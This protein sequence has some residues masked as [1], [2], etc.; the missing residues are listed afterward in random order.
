MNLGMM[1]QKRILS[2]ACLLALFS[3]PT[4]A[5][6]FDE[7]AVINQRIG[8]GRPI[9]APSSTEPFSKASAG[10]NVDL[11]CSAM[12]LNSEMLGSF[13]SGAFK[14]LQSSLV[15]QLMA[16]VNP[17]SLI[18][19]AIQRA[20][21]DVYDM[22][23][24]GSMTATDAFNANVMTCQ[25]MQQGVFDSLPAGALKN[26]TVSEEY[27]EAIKKHANGN[28]QL[29]DLVF[30]DGSAGR[31][32][33]DG[34]K[35]VDFGVEKRG[36]IGKPIKVTEHTSYAGFNALAG[37]AATDSSPLPTSATNAMG[38]GAVFK[39]PRE[40]NT[41]ISDVVGETRMYTDSDASP[42][43]EDRGIGAK[44]AYAKEF[45]ATNSKLLD[46]AR[47]PS[48]SITAKDLES[49]STSSIKVTRDLL[50]AIKQ[51]HPTEQAAYVAALATDI[52]M[53]NTY[54]KLL[55][56]VRIMDAGLRDESVTNNE[57]VRSETLHKRALLIQEMDLLERE[58]RFKKELAGSAQIDIL[59]RANME[60]KPGSYRTPTNELP[61]GTAN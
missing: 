22:L 14:Q 52:S 40:A 28:Y 54:E 12:S 18:G 45:D 49:A 9:D 19:M 3:G 43:E 36:M 32:Y 48:S 42:R 30:K 17:T 23:M 60:N 25:E 10:W 35:G 6:Q 24:S 53:A 16:A 55:H 29:K 2:V 51:I 47:R 20:N 15:G 34:K 4:W 39:S 1:M 8:G 46:L 37:R 38:M 59:R 27:A 33:D 50:L 21:P 7:R 56:S 31:S 57:A 5:A 11:S 41:F 58:L 61:V 44:A 26:L 13:N